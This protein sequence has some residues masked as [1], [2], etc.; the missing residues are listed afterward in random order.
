MFQPKRQ[1]AEGGVMASP[2][3]GSLTGAAAA[4]RT[5]R[6]LMRRVTKEGRR[7]EV[8]HP[9]AAGLRV[10]GE[11]TGT[12]S[13]VWYGSEPSGARKLFHLGYFRDVNA[14][15][16]A[17]ALQELKLRRKV[18]VATGHPMMRCEPRRDLSGL[19]MRGLVAL[20][21]WK[22]L[23]R[24][25]APRSPLLALKN[26]VLD[27]LGEVPVA[28]VTPDDVR[29]VIERLEAAGKHVQAARV[30]ALLKQAFRVGVKHGAISRSPAADIT[31]SD[32]DLDI[33]PRKRRFS[34]DELG[35]LW[36]ALHVNPE[37]PTNRVS[38]YALAILLATGRRCGEL[39][40]A[41]REHVDLVAA[42]WRVPAEDRKGKVSAQLEDDLVHLPRQVIPLFRAMF[43]AAPASPW[44]CATPL[45]SRSGH[46]GAGTLVR[47]LHELHADGTVKLGEPAV[48]HDFRRSIRSTLTE[49]RW[50]STV[51]AELIL[52]HKIPGIVGVYDVASY[53]EERASALQRWADHLDAL[54]GRTATDVVDLDA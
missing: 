16:A 20:F 12:I 30:L 19:T 31:R 9:A 11:P 41:R 39:L 10:R 18:A 23:R 17:E 35:S 40:H 26:H 50:A 53:D 54:A 44:V 13:F 21:A 28:A 34:A 3:G 8:A 49:K 2:N 6:A 51:V 15:Q 43:E 4:D 33:T 47:A 42:R 14:A 32:F 45:D 24:R 52:G 1:P 29:D 25:K 38:R 48:V 46:L 5:I 22:K 7:V 36:G 27:D 37:N